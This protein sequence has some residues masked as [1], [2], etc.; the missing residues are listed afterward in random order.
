MIAGE[1]PRDLQQAAELLWSQL[2]GPRC[3]LDVT[4]SADVGAALEE[5][6]GRLAD[7]AT[8]ARDAADRF[9]E[10]DRWV[11]A[12]DD[13]GESHDDHGGHE[14]HGGH[15][16][17]EEHGGH[18]HGDMSMSPSGIPLAERDED[19]DGLEMDELLHP[20]G[21]LLD[22][23]PGG[24]EMQLRLHGDVVA[25]AEAWWWGP[26]R[27][28]S[29]SEV[30]GWDAI[31]TTLALI[32]DDRFAHRA[33]VAR[34][35]DPSAAG[36][37]SAH[38]RRLARLG[39]LP[40]SASTTLTAFADGVAPPGTVPVDP[41]ELVQGLDLADARLVL[42]AHAPLLA[43]DLGRTPEAPDSHDHESDDVSDH[44]GGGHG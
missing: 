42:A 14:E 18:D 17:H 29:W 1:L 12:Q 8:Q 2:P 34:N 36:R 33:R 31:A 41:A 32:G 3:R 4:H 23:W 6:P 19:R 22:H 38:V 11:T 25:G 35:G 39:V 27:D 37:V 40:A 26:A 30:E 43:R 44:H 9:D 16:G 5:L 20:W 28:D 15:E 24:L 13:H 10:V 7:T 21:P